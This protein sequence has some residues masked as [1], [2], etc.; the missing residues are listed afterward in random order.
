MPDSDMQMLVIE[1]NSDRLGNDL[2]LPAESPENIE[3]QTL[4]RKIRSSHP[5]RVPKIQT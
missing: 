2:Y 4:E 1:K 3:F 5:P